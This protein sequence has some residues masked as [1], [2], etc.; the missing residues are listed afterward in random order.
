MTPFRAGFY[1]GTF[2]V[3]VA[4][5]ANFY[6]LFFDPAQTRDWVLAALA[7]FMPVVALSAYL[8]LTILGALRVQ[9]DRQEP[10]TTRRSQLLRSGALVGVMIGVLVGLAA[11]FSTLL[12]ATVLAESMRSFAAEAAPRIAAYVEE[13]RSGVSE[14]PPPTTVEQVERSLNPPQLRDLGRGIFTTVLLA[15]V[16]GIVGGVVGTLRGRPE[17]EKARPPERPGRGTP[18]PTGS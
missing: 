17:S 5:A 6:F 7:S 14:P 3:L 12:Q 2:A 10:G 16:L 1:Y 18:P 15:A 8:F 13:V 9:P 11:L 4:L